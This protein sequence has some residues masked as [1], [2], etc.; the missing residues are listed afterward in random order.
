MRDEKSDLINSIWNLIL[1]L[2]FR[3]W[4]KKFSNLL[5]RMG[6]RAFKYYLHILPLLSLTKR[7]K[8]KKRWEK[9]R[10]IAYK[11]IRAKIIKIITKLSLMNKQSIMKIKS[12]YYKHRIFRSKEYSEAK[13]EKHLT[14]FRS[15]QCN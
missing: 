14:E 13:W 4:L 2:M 3:T 8:Q 15:T 9:H 5:K 10:E 6:L 12:K 11:S 7:N 1:L